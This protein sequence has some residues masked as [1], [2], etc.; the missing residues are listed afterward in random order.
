MTGEQLH[1]DIAGLQVKVE[2]LTVLHAETRADV[3]A[4]RSQLDQMR[5]GKAALF[6]LLALAGGIGAIVTQALHWFRG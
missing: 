4:M 3:K 2:S 5:G 1:R 6:G